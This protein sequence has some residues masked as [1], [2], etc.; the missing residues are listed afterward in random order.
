M[1]RMAMRKLH[2]STDKRKTVIKKWMWKFTRTFLLLGLSF[3]LLYPL[4]YMVSM[5]VRPM[6]QVY[7]PTVIWIPRSFTLENIRFVF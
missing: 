5:S 2:A 6:D 1:D 3:V 4:I 7:D